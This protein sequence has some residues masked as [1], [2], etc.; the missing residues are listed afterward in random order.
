MIK[1][2][3]Q[4]LQKITCNAA[5]FGGVH[6]ILVGDRCQLRPMGKWIFEDLSVVYGPL[7]TNVWKD[8]VKM[9]ELTEIMRQK[10]DRSFAEI[11]NRLRENIQT[12]DDIKE[13]ESCVLNVPQHDPTYPQHVPHL[14]PRNSEVNAFNE[15]M[16]LLSSQTKTTI[17]AHDIIINVTEND[18]KMKIM[19]SI[20]TS[21]K[22]Q[23]ANNTDNLP[24]TLQLA[25]GL[26]YSTTLNLCVDDGLTN[27][28]CCT[29][30]YI[31][32][33]SGIERP[34]I[35]W[36]QF[37]ESDMGA[38][39]R[40]KHRHLYFH[41]TNSPANH[42]PQKK[43]WTPICAE[44]REFKVGHAR[45]ARTQ[46]PLTPCSARTLHKAQGS[47]YASE[48][49]DMGNSTFCHGHYT[50]FSRVTSKKGLHIIRLNASKIK[51]DPKVQQELQRLRRYAC[52][53]ICYQPV[54]HISATKHKIVFKM[55]AL[56]IFTSPM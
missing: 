40:V 47:T 17:H 56:Y 36:V 54:S 6:M 41:K 53:H 27:G 38:D 45:I 7:A 24:T 34:A 43:N 39:H 8:N 15:K 46:L 12:E 1:E 32:Y 31:E 55:L 2:I 51:L 42:P 20:T 9:F 21:Q 5:L 11:L 14:F 10:E 48:V 22:Y 28:S 49:V 33:R 13:L 29:L 30:H 44:K 37:V 35:L 25:Q 3:H 18:K 16:F 19:N 52:L 50:A 23:T 4:C 26:P